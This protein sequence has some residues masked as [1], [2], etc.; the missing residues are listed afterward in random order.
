MAP[1][2]RSMFDLACYAKLASWACTAASF[3]LKSADLDDAAL[4][5]DLGARSIE[6]G[7]AL[8]DRPRDV[9]RKAADRL[10]KRL[11]RDHRAWLEH[12][13][14]ADTLARQ[15]IE[16]IFAALDD[17]LQKTLPSAEE[18]AQANLNAS[19]IADRVVER[20]GADEQFSKG[21]FGGQLLHVL[22][23]HAYEA[24]L[25][26]ESFEQDLRLAISRVLLERTQETVETTQRIEAMLTAGAA[27]LS[28][29]QRH[30]LRKQPTDERELLLTELR[31]T[32]LVGREGDLTALQAWLDSPRTI[33]A[34][35]IT[36]QA[37]AGKTRLALELCERAEKAGWAVGFARQEE[38]ALFRTAHSPSDW[39]WPR[40]TLVVVDYAAASVQILRSWLEVLA[41]RPDQPVPQPLR[42]LL[43][44]RYADPQAGWWAELTRPGGSSGR[45][46]RDVLDPA[47]PIPLRPLVAVADRRALLTEAMAEAARIGKVAPTPVPPPEGVDALFDQRLGK[48]AIETEPLYLMMAAVVAVRTGAPA[49]LALS[50]LELVA[51]VANADEIAGSER[52]RLI[53]RAR[54]ANVSE[55][56]LL[57]AAA[58]VTLQQGCDDDALLTLVEQERAILGSGGEAAEDLAALLR[59]ALAAP[60]GSGAD[61]VRPDLIGEAFLLHELARDHRSVARQAAIVE[62]AFRRDSSRVVETVIR[63]AQDHAL[64]DASHP[65]VEW[66][67]HLA[68]LAEDPF[69]LMAIAAELP[70]QTL[71]LRERAVEIT[72]R[73][74]TAL[75]HRAADDPDLI[76]AMAQWSSNLGVR[77]SELGE[78]EAALAAAQEAVELCRALAAQRPD[79]FR[80]NLAVSLNNLANMLSELGEREAALAAAQEAVDIRRA[81]A[82]Q[83]PDAF[84]PDLAGS[85]NNLAN[86]LSEVGEREAA[87]AAAQEAVDIRRALAA[88]R[89]DA[90]RPNLA[91]SLNNLANML[92]ELGEREAAL[93]AAQEAVDI[94]RALAAQR[95]DAFRPDLA[96]S[97]NNLAN[98]LSEL[99][100]REAA[101]AAAQEAVELYRALA[102]QRPD[103]FRPDLAM[104]LN[105]L[106]NRLSEV[107]EREAAL[108]AAQEAV[109]LY[110]ALAAQRPDAFRPDLAGS[111]NNLANRL[112]ELG[113]REAALAAAQEAVELYRALAAQRPDAFRPDLAGSLNNLANRLSE[114]GE[115]EAALAAAQEAVE[116]YRALAA[117]RPDAF[118]PNLAVSLNNLANMLSEL[119]EREAALAA[120]QEAVELY[121]ALA[122]QRPD[123]FRP[124][125]A[126]SLNNLANR[127]S[128]LGEREAALAAAQEAV[129]LYRA[130]AAQRPDAFRPDLAM[131][132]NNL[133]NSLSELGEREAA[134]AAAQEAVELYRAHRRAATRRLPARPC[135]VAEQ[136]R[137]H[138][139]RGRRARGGAGGGAGGGGHSSR[140]RRAATRRL[141]ARPCGVAEQSR[142]QAERARR[143]RGGAGG[144]AGG[145]R[146]V[147]R[148]RRAATRRLPA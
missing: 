111:L 134:L 80:P 87:L 97:L 54:A 43:L 50:R 63:T 39:Q 114:L 32:T 145:G 112:S 99:G 31:A 84:R 40:K 38:L 86:M 148:P 9:V 28:L 93:A 41:R 53:R 79:A 61:A 108:A 69:I 76:P 52:N 2:G 127:L 12:E 8:H 36:G 94:R 49:A 118:R 17:V 60:D 23:T 42:I 90:F 64:G 48:H 107:G 77:L 47:A 10:A 3:A 68:H 24:A 130:L 35:C 139:E 4:L 120:A 88:Q 144:G 91:V 103:A 115:R 146:T 129:E 123:A 81:L 71:A 27:H 11:E 58:C 106:A 83:R 98:R 82:A 135:G 72:Q 142:Q 141:P 56:L 128:E 7:H 62:R 66:L 18:V 26:D 102:A 109:E 147:S 25:N 6:A 110:R 143:A 113:E 101:L 105:N 37:G 121:R 21:T 59:D 1:G 15:D 96:G 22:V 126:G 75:A 30:R 29:D 140:P 16:A 44:E 124:D 5:A 133:A 74:V 131:S 119:G 46:P 14:G 57:H 117:Q 92:S 34:R 95:P 136:S 125:L 13:F 85:L 45:D 70:D 132:L 73:I 20:A 100:E 116:L 55:R 122:A 89:P 78:R 104:S 19:A 51:K 65:S 138:A 67:D 33:S 137:Q